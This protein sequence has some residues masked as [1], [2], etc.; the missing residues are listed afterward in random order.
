MFASEQAAVG[1]RSL[2]GG[3]SR[4]DQEKQPPTGPSSCYSG[5]FLLGVSFFFFSTSSYSLTHVESFRWESAGKGRWSR[6]GWG[7]P[8]SLASCPLSLSD[9][10][11]SLSCLRVTCISSCVIGKCHSV[12]T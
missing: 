4:C 3:W 1:D 2:L 7:F 5:S 10:T 6:A 12:Y 9:I 11:L 8:C